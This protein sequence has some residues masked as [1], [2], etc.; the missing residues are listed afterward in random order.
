MAYEP[1]NSSWR[2]SGLAQR[3]LRFERSRV[4]R[5]RLQRQSDRLI[6]VAVRQR[7]LRTGNER[8]IPRFGRVAL[9][10]IALVEGKRAETRRY[11]QEHC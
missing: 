4:E 1:A 3:H 5:H 8:Q 10:A 11:E 2:I 6:G 9:G 7:G